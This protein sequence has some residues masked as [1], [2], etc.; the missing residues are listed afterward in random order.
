MTTHDHLTDADMGDVVR[1]RLNASA[2]RISAPDLWPS[3]SERMDGASRRNGSLLRPPRWLASVGTVLFITL[4]VV[5]WVML[6]DGQDN[7]APVAAEPSYSRL[8]GGSLEEDPGTPVDVAVFSEIFSRLDNAGPFRVEGELFT[9]SRPRGV[10]STLQNAN[11]GPALGQEE[12]RGRFL[13]NGFVE[14]ECV[15]NGPDKACLLG[16]DELWQSTFKLPPEC[17]SMTERPA[18]IC[19][20]S[21]ATMIPTFVSIT[22][23]ATMY[24]EGGTYTFKSLYQAPDL[25]RIE[26]TLRIDPEFKAEVAAKIPAV[27]LIEAERTVTLRQQRIRY[28]DSSSPAPGGYGF[29]NTGTSEGFVAAHLNPFLSEPPPGSLDAAVTFEDV[30]LISSSDPSTGYRYQASISGGIGEFGTWDMWVGE[31]GLPRQITI[32]VFSSPQWRGGTG[33]EVQTTRVSLTFFDYGEPV[34]ADDPIQRLQ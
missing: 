9:T 24:K 29:I 27:K 3:V 15:E 5:V 16:M 14:I 19:E 33:D 20:N 4:S 25:Y 34:D 8:L 23:F 21:L 28:F 31:D 11:G 12:F 7:E 10:V 6:V 26:R 30:R 1:N 18:E 32:E 17:T 13:N 2:Q 22:P